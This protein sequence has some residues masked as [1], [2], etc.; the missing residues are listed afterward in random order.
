MSDEQT[1]LTVEDRRILWGVLIG[2]HKAITK[3]HHA[4]MRHIHNIETAT[5]P[6]VKESYEKQERIANTA[7]FSKAYCISDLQDALGEIGKGLSI[8]ELEQE[9]GQ[10]PKVYP[11]KTS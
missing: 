2:W 11:P 1:I 10:L 4:T 5:T 9:F 8:F 7:Y 6:E 3:H